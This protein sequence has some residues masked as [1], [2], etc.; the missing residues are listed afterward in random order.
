MYRLIGDLSGPGFFTVNE[1][2]GVISV[3][4][5]LGLDPTTRYTLRVEVS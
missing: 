5:D 4:N 2:T 3:R 1:T